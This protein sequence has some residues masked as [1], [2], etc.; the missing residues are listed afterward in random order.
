MNES[1][2]DASQEPQDAP[3]AR[4]GAERRLAF[5]DFQLR[6]EG[7]LNRADL[8]RR[9][10]IS[11]PQASLDIAKYS[12]AAPQNLQYDHSTRVYVAKDTFV[13][14]VP[15]NGPERYLNE[16][17]AVETGLLP[18]E[19]SFLN[20]RPA[21][22]GVPQ[23][24]RIVGDKTLATIL[25]AIRESSGVRVL[26]QSMSS[27]EPSDRVISPT[28]L[29]NDGFR[30]HVRAY[31][32]V[33]N[34]FRDFVLGRIIE[35]LETSPLGAQGPDEGWDNLL[36]L[37]IEPNPRLPEAKRKVIELD[38][39]MTNGEA[40]VVCRQALLFYTLKKLGLTNYDDAPESQHIVLKN[41][42]ELKPY[43]AAES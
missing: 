34:E 5:I 28:A 23:P 9:F 16:L 43:L 27:L 37:V 13:P 33:R 25:R 14:L 30:W 41:R 11:T 22:G 29:G 20:W 17:M 40:E 42:E 1:Q 39:G 15:N 2:D 6:W 38:Y 36:R 21:F 35:I 4:G 10:G 18:L 24:Y 7:R 32:H 8:T 3:R 12:G 31:C 26:Y 19:E